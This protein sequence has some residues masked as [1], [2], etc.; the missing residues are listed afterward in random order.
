MIIEGN[1][2]TPSISEK[3]TGKIYFEI[4]E[5]KSITYQNVRDTAKECLKGEFIAVWTNNLK[6]LP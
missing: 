6:F 3:I 1:F 5:N 2:G 4:N